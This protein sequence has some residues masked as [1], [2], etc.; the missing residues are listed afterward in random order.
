MFVMRNLNIIFVFFL[1]ALVLG[2]GRRIHVS[3]DYDRDANFHEYYTYTVQM[4]TEEERPTSIFNKRVKS[5]IR[6]EMAMRG[7]RYVEP[8]QNPDLTVF[9]YRE[10]E[11]RQEVFRDYHFAPPMGFWG[12]YRPYW[13]GSWGWGGPWGWGGMPIDRVR[14]R[15][16]N[17]MTI[18]VVDN[19]TN[20]L[21]WQGWAVTDAT[22][23]ERTYEQRLE[24]A[25]EKVR[26]IMEEY[27]FRATSR[28]LTPEEMPR[29]QN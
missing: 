6:D 2:C 19:R 26:S 4:G 21:V 11:R 7:Y 20:E 12:G 13:G 18:D 5:F 22:G 23:R 3:S 16:E 10:Q 14:T 9:L 27:E 15:I 28:P 29:V 1:S 24:N 25:R 17:R 8:N